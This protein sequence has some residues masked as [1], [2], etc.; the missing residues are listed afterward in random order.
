MLALD[1]LSERSDLNSRVFP[2][3]RVHKKLWNISPK[4]T[5]AML[6]VEN[7]SSNAVGRK[8]FG[9]HNDSFKPLD[10]PSKTTRMSVSPFGTAK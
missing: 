8:Q 2:D 7:E 4:S 5:S 10:V 6:N 3:S 1:V 9:A